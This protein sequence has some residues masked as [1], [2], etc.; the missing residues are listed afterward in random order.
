MENLVNET[1]SNF[2]G[3]DILVCNAALNPFFGSS[4]D[5]PDDAFDK[6]LSANIKSNHW[7]SNMV[8]PQMIERKEGSIIVISSIGGLKDLKC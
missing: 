4:M 8:L 1:N 5:I 3:I 2:G 6:I 7:L